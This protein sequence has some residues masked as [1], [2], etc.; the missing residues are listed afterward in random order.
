MASYPVEGDIYLFLAGYDDAPHTLLSYSQITTKLCFRTPP[1]LPSAITRRSL[2]PSLLRNGFVS[3]K[4]NR[5][6]FPFRTSP[7]PSTRLP[8][9][10]NTSRATYQ[11]TPKPLTL[12]LREIPQKPYVNGSGKEKTAGLRIPYFPSGFTVGTALS[13]DLSEVSD[14]D[15]AIPM[16]DGDRPKKTV[17]HVEFLN[18]AYGEKSHMKQ[19]RARSTRGAFATLAAEEIQ[20]IFVALGPQFPYTLDQIKVLSIDVRSRGTVQPRI[21]VAAEALES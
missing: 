13:G 20:K 17:L 14:A 1:T 16:L 18:P 2:T 6:I 3:P 12:H 4:T 11:S 21:F 10:C 15:G 5:P 9:L 19:R 7:K 8:T